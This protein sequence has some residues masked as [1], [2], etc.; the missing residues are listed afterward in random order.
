MG[1]GGDIKYESVLS[2]A[3]F[4]CTVWY[5]GRLAKTFKL[6][7]IPFEICVGML[8]G[9]NGVDLIPDFSSSYSPLQLLGFI[10]VGIGNI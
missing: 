1:G 3:L 2:L 6:P 7:T 5:V 10:G 4:L 9:P 8:F